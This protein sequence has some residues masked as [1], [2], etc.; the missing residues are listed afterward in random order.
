MAAEARFFGK[1]EWFGVRRRANS[2]ALRVGR[3]EKRCQK[4]VKTSLGIVNLVAAVECIGS[5]QI[6]FQ[7]VCGLFDRHFRLENEHQVFAFDDRATN[8]LCDRDAYE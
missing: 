6:L 2:S 5:R 7:I 8:E 3:V 4:G 1:Q